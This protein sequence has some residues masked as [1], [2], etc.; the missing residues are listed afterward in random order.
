MTRALVFT[1]TKRGAN[2]VAEHLER[3]RV[4]VGVIHGNKSQGARVRALEAF[5]QGNARVLVATDI[6]ARGIDVQD[7][8]HVINFELPMDPESYVHRIGRTARAGRRGVALSFC[9]ASERGALK[10]IERLTGQRL[11]V[12]EHH[13]LAGSSETSP[14]AKGGSSRPGWER[15]AS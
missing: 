1:R 14:A 10:D 13:P 4:A 6:A 8:T 15:R 12:V 9:D 5:R 7:V 2:R 11:K 3:N